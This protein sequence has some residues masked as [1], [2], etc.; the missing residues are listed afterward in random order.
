MLAPLHR[1]LGFLWQHPLG[2]RH[3]LRCLLRA[4]SWQLRS[5]LQPGPISCPWIGGTRLL[6]SRGMT[7]ATGNLY[8]GL[9]EW[10][11][12]AFL[13]HLLRPGDHFLDVGSNVGSYS[14]LAAGV[15][16]ASA[17]A[18]EPTAAA[19][20]GLRANIAANGLEQLIT[21]EPV[22][23]G[24]TSGS[25][26]FTEDLGPMNQ[27]AAPGYA[28]H[29]RQVPLLPL[30]EL[31]ATATALCWKVDVEGQE[32]AVL[33]GARRSLASPTLAAVLLEGRQPEVLQAMAAHGFQPCSYDPFSRRLTPGADAKG[34]NQL[35][36]R[37]L[38]LV[39]QRLATAPAFSVLGDTL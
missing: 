13:L 33:A 14:I 4:A 21:I 37:N 28:G 29:T 39:S 30:D 3:R 25:V 32:P 10:P 38:P 17:T 31:P 35:W 27:R 8:V 18:I 34:A 15:C 26:A 9:H 2:R 23:V 16:G 11:D 6:V 7:G 12:M 1:S 5:R 20:T 19:L 36:V 24:E 22:C